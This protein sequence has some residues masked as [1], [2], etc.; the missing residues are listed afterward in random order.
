MLNGET[1]LVLKKITE[2]L[3]LDEKMLGVVFNYAKLLY[4]SGEYEG[5]KLYQTLEA[6]RL[7]YFLEHKSNDKEDMM[8]ALWGQ[9]SGHIML[10]QKEKYRYDFIRLK[11]IIDSLVPCL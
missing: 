8:R 1:E 7:L 5:N 11:D 10:D 2:G 9:L 6:V 3:E 4:D